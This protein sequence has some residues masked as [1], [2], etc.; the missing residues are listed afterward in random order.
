MIHPK[1]SNH[2]TASPLSAQLGSLPLL[3]EVT[4]QAPP[5]LFAYSSSIRSSYILSAAISASVLVLVPPLAVV[6]A[7]L[8]TPLRYSEL[9]AVSPE[10]T[11][12]DVEELDGISMVCFVGADMLK[13]SCLNATEIFLLDRELW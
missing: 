10:V 5:S 8:S 4:A 12:S 7:L 6:L 11:L 13:F 3:V 2:T 1:T 9:D